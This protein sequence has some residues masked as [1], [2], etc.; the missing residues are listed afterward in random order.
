MGRRWLLR[1]YGRALVL[2][3]GRTDWGS[4]GF[5]DGVLLDVHVDWGLSRYE[6]SRRAGQVIAT[7]NEQAQL[8]KA[9]LLGVYIQ[10]TR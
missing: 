4:C 7:E 1:G 9:R 8:A 6:L 5:S 3:F 2:E 10:P